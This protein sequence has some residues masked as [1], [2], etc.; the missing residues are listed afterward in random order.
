MARRRRAPTVAKGDEIVD[1]ET[2]KIANAFESPVGRLLR[3]L[4]AERRRRDLPV[5]ALLG[6]VADAE[7][8]DAEI[9]AFVAEFQAAFAARRGRGGRRA[10]S[11]RS[12]RSA[13]GDPALPDAR[14]RAASAVVLLHGFGGDLN[15]WLFNQPPLAAGPH[16]LRARPAR[17]TAARQGRR[18][19]R[20]RARSRTRCSEFLD[21]VGHRARRT[22]SGHSLGGAR[23]R[24]ERGA[25]RSRPRALAD[26]ASRRAGLGEEINARLP[27]RL[28]RGRAAGVSSSPLLELLFADRGW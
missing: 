26:A 16:R 17:A 14:A 6:V 13:A 22:S 19:R 28:R 15:N 10:R 9:D 4:V 11:P 18:R 5:G 8:A 23:R 7:V 2:D 25:A 12:S 1:I 3:R 27:R 21:A 20:S 24:G